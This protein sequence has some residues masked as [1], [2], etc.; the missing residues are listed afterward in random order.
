MRFAVDDLDV[1]LALLRDGLDGVTVM[2]KIPDGLPDHTP[3]VVAARTGGS[4]PRPEFYDGPDYT[5]QCWAAPTRT[6]P[7][8]SRAACDLADQAR[9]VLY[10]AWRTQRVIPEAGHLVGW[11]ET[12]GP[13]E[14]PDPDLPHF[15]RFVQTVGL[16]VRPALRPLP[17]PGSGV[18]AA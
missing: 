5:L 9:G 15:G 3:L 10:R 6:Q 7:D 1:V 11:Q 16:R 13:L 17:A 12:Q 8:A 14:V 18:T 2:S 4:S